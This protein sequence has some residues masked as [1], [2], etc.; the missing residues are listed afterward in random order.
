MVCVHVKPSIVSL[1]QLLGSSKSVSGSEPSSV[2][3]WK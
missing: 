1:W 3:S 2:V